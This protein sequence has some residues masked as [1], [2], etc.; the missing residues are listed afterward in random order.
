MRVW[1]LASV[2]LWVCAAARAAEDPAVL[3]REALAQ[4]DSAQVQLE[5]AQTAPDRVKALT[6]VIRS[7]EE[8]LEAM[9]SGMRQVALRDSEL[10]RSFQ[11]ES[12]QLSELLGVLA[13]LNPD[14]AP[15]ALVHPNGP[16]GH[17]RA[18][19]LV[20][21]VTP[22]VQAEVERLRIQL[23][24]VQ[25][26]RE[27]QDTAIST[28]ETGLKSVQT[29]R[30]GLS[31]AMSDRVDLP[32]R[33][34]SDPDRMA[35]LIESSE[36]LS[37]FA[38][39]LAV[40]DVVDGIDALPDLSSAKGSWSFPAQGKLLRGFEK[41]DAAGV[42]RPGWLWVT[43][44]LAVVTSPWPATIRYRGPFL[45]YGNV[46]ILEPGNDV[47]LVLAGLDEVYGEPGQVISAGAAVGLMGGQAP[48]LAEFVE[49]ATQGSGAG[50]TE[51]LYIEIR[52][53]GE[54]VNP[55]T[56]FANAPL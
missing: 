55:E 11:D 1:A 26:L 15:D 47:L 24:E 2:I 50:L 8:G 13:A 16:V 30:T 40:M 3:A 32:R 20:S 7:F 56:W 49:N 21:S 37:S 52:E 9:R 14:V 10:T 33:F 18:G 6:S 44:P 41:T 36:T 39:G 34:A 5:Q 54:P 53:G 4:F 17:A 35:V 19:M 12:G 25:I 48:E 45:D 28:L 43:R 31:Q 22:A 23:E 51:T 46:I 42:S 27:L 29:A 38:S